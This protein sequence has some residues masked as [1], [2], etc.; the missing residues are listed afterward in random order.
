[1][2]A[3]KSSPIYRL[4]VIG[5]LI[6]IVAFA[7]IG[8]LS[9]PTDQSLIFWLIPM[10]AVYMGLIFFLQYRQVDRAVEA[11]PELNEPSAGL[12]RWNIVFGAILC[13]AIF[14]GVAAFYAGV[15]TT[16]YPLGESGPGFPLVLLPAI[17]LVLIGAGRAM[18]TLRSYRRGELPGQK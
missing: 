5:G 13:V 11:D 17:G 16:Y 6:A 9:D 12:V 7:V 18:A 4:W 2:D 8:G 10:L 15:D 14:T 1:M 3:W